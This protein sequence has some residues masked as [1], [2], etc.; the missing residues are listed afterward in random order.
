MMTPRKLK[1]L[2]KSIHTAAY[3]V[4][5]PC[6]LGVDR[7]KWAEATNALFNANGQIDRMVKG[8]EKN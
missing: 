8:M 6:P 5:C 7:D 4:A 1:N 2:Q 3:L